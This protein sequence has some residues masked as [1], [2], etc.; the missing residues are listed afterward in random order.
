MWMTVLFSFC[1]ISISAVLIWS[2]WQ[3]W[4]SV[5]AEASAEPSGGFRRRQ[6]R[7]RTMSSTAIGLIGIA[8]LASPRMVDPVRLSFWFYWSGVLFAVI[9]IGLLALLDM[10]S[11]RVHFSKQHAGLADQIALQAQ[12]AR[13]HSRQGNEDQRIDT[14]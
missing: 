6:F 10:I 14:S 12:L 11:T 3:T 5:Q 1:L 4:R 7:R 9:S 2:H 13:R 8:L